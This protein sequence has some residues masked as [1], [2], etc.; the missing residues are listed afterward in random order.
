MYVYVECLEMC[1][2]VRLRSLTKEKNRKVDF[3]NIISQKLFTY[4][5]SAPC[6]RCMR[7]YRKLFSSR[8]VMEGKKDLNNLHHLTTNMRPVLYTFFCVYAQCSC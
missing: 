4:P 7:L 3:L 5:F 6:N 8:G 1:M 2:C